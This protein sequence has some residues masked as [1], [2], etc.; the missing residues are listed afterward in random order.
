MAEEVLNFKRA[1]RLVLLGWAG[2]GKSASGNTILGNNEFIS[3]RRSSKCESRRTYVAGRDVT[4]VDT[5]GWIDLSV[6]DTPESIEKEIVSSGVPAPDAVLL[7]IPLHMEVTE[8]Y[9]HSVIEHVSLLGDSVW[10]QTILLF[11]FGRCLQNCTIEDHIERNKAL[12]NLMMMCRNHYHVFENANG[13]D[14]EQVENLLIKIE[15]LCLSSNFIEHPEEVQYVSKSTQTENTDD[16]TSEIQ[17]EKPAKPKSNGMQSFPELRIMLLGLYRS[18]KSTTG[19]NIL[20]DN[21]FK[22]WTARSQREEAEVAGRNVVVIDTPPWRNATGISPD[23]N[24][25]NWVCQCPPGPHAFIFVL[26]L[27]AKFTPEHWKSVQIYMQMLGEQ[28]WEHVIV[29]FTG[30]DILE[31]MDMKSYMRNKN[32]SLQKLLQKCGNRFYFFNNKNRGHSTQVTD[33]IEGIERLSS[34]NSTRFYEMDKTMTKSMEEMKQTLQ[35]KAQKRHHMVAVRQNEQNVIF[36]GGKPHT[37]TEVRIVLLGEKGSGKTSASKMMATLFYKEDKNECVDIKT[38]I[39]NRMIQIVDT[40]GWSTSWRHPVLKQGVITEALSLCHPGPHALLIVVNLRHSFTD[41]NR[42]ALEQN[43]ACF[44]S[45]LWRNAM[46]LFTGGERLQGESIELHIER[47]G[48]ALQWLVQKCDHRYS[49]LRDTPFDDLPQIRELL[50]EID[51]MVEANS[52]QYFSNTIHNQTSLSEKPSDPTVMEDNEF[53]YTER[54]EKMMERMMKTIRE[55]L[56][57]DIKNFLSTYRRT[58]ES[59]SDI[60]PNMSEGQPTSEDFLKGRQRGGQSYGATSA[61]ESDLNADI[62]DLEVHPE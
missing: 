41:K 24:I 14:D 11:T 57:L 7:L 62:D 50:Q 37:L 46:V 10:S 38:S 51:K 8:G 48:E 49:V 30:A 45:S 42:A 54:E 23:Q 2:S 56:Q 44:S 5:P 43:L 61:Y 4:V 13:G 35:E 20:G 27:S 22:E 47:E 52:G 17:D 19:N 39:D 28:V 16:Q 58:G 9:I 6:H 15:N 40:P 29:V 26:N 59:L 60:F 55:K 25:V 18:G 31:G 36:R 33:L 21:R 32:E 53:R 34:Q 3:G 1:F 12:H